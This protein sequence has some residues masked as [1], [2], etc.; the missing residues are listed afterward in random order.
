MRGPSGPLARTVRTADRPASGPDRPPAQKRAQQA[1]YIVAVVD[2]IT[3]V[4]CTKNG[5]PNLYLCFQRL[6]VKV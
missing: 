2:N 3:N 1:D 6:G 5:C 4:V